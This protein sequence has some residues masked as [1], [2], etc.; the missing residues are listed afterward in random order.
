[1]KF[2]AIL[3]GLLMWTT[4]KQKD[5]NVELSEDENAKLI[6]EI[7]AEDASLLISQVNAELAGVKSAKAQLAEAKTE[8]AAQVQASEGDK[9][10]IEQLTKKIEDLS[11]QV[12]TQE[13]LISKL[14]DEPETNMKQFMG[15]AGEILGKAFEIGGKLLGLDAGASGNLWAIDRPW[16]VSALSGA[17]GSTTDFRSSAAIETLN[18]D[19][20]DFQQEYPDK[21]DSYFTDFLKL[22]EHWKAEIGSLAT[23]LSIGISVGEVTQPRKAFWMPKGNIVFKVEE[24]KPD[25]VQI[26]LQFN[27][28]EMQ[29]IERNWLRMFNKE[30]AFAYKM[31]F[32][33]YLL[34][35]YLQKARQED[36]S[37]AI[38]GVKVETPE[39]FQPQKTGKAVSYL[40]RTD[41]L[42]K[43]VFD[44]KV[45]GKYRPFNLGMV[46]S[47][48]NSVDYIDGFL[49]QVPK[50]AF[51][52]GTL[53][54]VIDPQMATDYKN[55]DEEIRGGNNNY[56]G[57]PTNPRDYSNV[58]FVPVEQLR[59]TNFMML[60][61]WDNIGT[62]EDAE[63]GKKI[64][65]IEK[66]LRDVYVFGDYYFGLRIKHIGLPTVE[67]DA[68]AMSKQLI[69]TNDVPMFSANFFS[70]AYDDT[71]GIMRVNHNRVKP[72]GGFST[73]IAKIEGNVG[74]F[75]I[76]RGDVSMA[77]AVKV[78]M[79]ADLLLTADF[80][81]KLGGDLTLVKQANGK[82]KEVS[83]TAAP[84]VAPTSVNF[85]GTTIA[86]AASEYLYTGGA[87]ATLAGITGG[88]E[89]NTVRIYGGVDAG[90]ALTVADVSG[91]IDVASNAVLDSNAKYVDL[92]Y[93]G[94]VWT[95][96]GRG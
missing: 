63:K 75:L 53:Q 23:L 93:I 35:Y 49:N 55:R 12:S 22:P 13:G 39:D 87:A 26:D 17:K 47:Y 67:G 14:K 60:T 78:K 6:A 30:G 82:W 29:K 18:N 43:K 32:I 59:G 96:F 86:Y 34:S 10:A 3:M 31:T 16:N 4:F 42:L 44:A 58:E 20:L 11:T 94:G 52:I 57:Y 41:G 5:N 46:Y 33:E 40:N 92:V 85:T 48:A 36:A 1:M 88:V 70:T 89:G 28:W 51:G 68:L 15:T 45:A 8:L 38:L 81:L 24:F 79:N 76:L 65:T 83:R 80:N 69:W 77:T 37:V 74:N 71:T 27:Y 62:S 66:F 91:N 2:K 56:V 7:G 73:D 64:L 9:T 50:E 54:L 84:A 95:E 21:I 61:T 25:P 90:H 19:I 72:D